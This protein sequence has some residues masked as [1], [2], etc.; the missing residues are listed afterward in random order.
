MSY[1]KAPLRQQQ[2]LDCAKKVFAERGYHAANISHICAEAGIGRG[3]LYQYFRNKKAVFTAI[4]RDTL[5]RVKREMERR[6]RRG[7]PRPHRLARAAVVEWS[8]GRLQEIFDA[9]FQDEQTLRITLREAVGLDVDIETL[10]GEIDDS[11]IGIVEADLDAAKRAGIVRELD[12]HLVATL[13]VGGIEK[14]LLTAL[15]SDGPIDLRRM[16]TEASRLH[17]TGMLSD[18]VKDQPTE[19][20][21]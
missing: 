20:P 8:A 12:T 3:T 1:M 4:L 21:R 13:M 9:V 14:L 15:R 17:L 19:E 5:A 2:I 6:P 16:A 11:L 18:R 10:L 7:L